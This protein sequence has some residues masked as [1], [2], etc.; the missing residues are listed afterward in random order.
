M[1]FPIQYALSFPDRWENDFER[2]RLDELGELVF[3]PLDEGR[4]RAVG[5][6]RQALSRGESA[7]AVLNA[8]NE[9]AV[10]AFLDG[11]ISF[12]DI[13]ATVERTLEAHQPAPVESLAEALHWD[14]W[15]RRRADE[16][17][18]K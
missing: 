6:A 9:V 7:P 2:L 5:L 12:P 4:F 14:R 13:V 3:E 10:A 17:L 16:M 11:K 15:G 1:V 8:A 18:P